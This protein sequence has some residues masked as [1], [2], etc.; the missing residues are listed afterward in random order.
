MAD[1]EVAAGRLMQPF[2][3]R[4]PVK[5]NYHLV[6]SPYKARLAKVRAFRE[7]ILDESAYLRN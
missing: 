4:L 3:A 2:S 5:L 7:W 1:P 6:T